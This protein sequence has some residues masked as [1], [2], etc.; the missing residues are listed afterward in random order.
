MNWGDLRSYF[1]GVAAK[2]LTL[3]EVDASVSNGH[4]F[5]GV[6]KLRA[7]LGTESRRNIPTTYVL[8]KDDEPAETVRSSASWYDSRERDTDRSAEWRLY[9]PR[10]AAAIQARMKAGDL[11][12]VGLLPNHELAVFLASRGSLR[13]TEL[14]NLFGFEASDVGIDIAEMSAR[15]ALSFTAASILEDLGLGSAV[16]AAGADQR[17][18]AELASELI[19]SH[20]AGLPTGREVAS[21]IQQ[22]VS[23]VDAIADPDGTLHRWIEIQ[24]AVFRTWEDALIARRIDGGFLT[25]QGS[26][27]VNAFRTFT[28]TLRQSRV[29]R[30]G[31][32]L[33]LHV[34]R[35]LR[36]NRVRFDEQVITENNERPDLVFPGRDAY[37]DPSF[38]EQDLRMLAV[39][40]TV[41]DRWRQ[42]LNEADRI[43]PKHLLT[44][45]GAVTNSTINAMGAS[46]LLLVIP[47][48]VRREYS[49]HSRD[50][51]MPLREF[52]EDVGGDAHL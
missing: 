11:M 13:E 45:D 52:I 40:F 10:E 38:S 15:E 5:Q 7:V 37:H 6:G 25:P 39:K 32:A 1:R 44:M 17:L 21:L 20:G 16:P 31:G 4:E 3:T 47:E 43:N 18:A 12:V 35:V 50:R 28:M 48:P 27:D 19:A 34:A 14:I 41:K 49:D 24:A 33:Q 46:G 2:R 9:Y 29:S 26:A 42:V 23:D 22:R 30:A 8:W 36:L 51:I